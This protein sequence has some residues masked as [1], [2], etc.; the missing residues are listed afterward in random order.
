MS[1]H[2]KRLSRLNE[3]SADAVAAALVADKHIAFQGLLLL[4]V[5]YALLP[6]V[7]TESIVQQ[8]Q[9]VAQ[10]KYSKKAELRLTHPLLLNRLSR[11]MA[12]H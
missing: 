2:M 3:Y 4:T 9:E 11:I 12:T 1:Q 10:N 7:N 8:A 5:G 6:Y